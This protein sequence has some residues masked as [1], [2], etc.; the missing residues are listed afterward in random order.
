[1]MQNHPEIPSKNKFWTQHM[2][3][4]SK[5]SYGNLTE[6]WRFFQDLSRRTHLGPYGPQPGPGSNPDWA[7]TRARANRRYFWRGNWLTFVLSQYFEIMRKHKLG[8]SCRGFW[9]P[10]AKPCR[11][12]IKSYQKSCLDPKHAKF[13]KLSQLVLSVAV[14][15]SRT[16]PMAVQEDNS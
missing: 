16:C 13:V 11:I 14:Q 12:I 2:R 4:L 1:M 8:F 5:L 3:N 15:E 9:D 7:P 6:S 10:A